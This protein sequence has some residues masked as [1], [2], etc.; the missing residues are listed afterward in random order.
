MHGRL[1]EAGYVAWTG[2]QV[3]E[4]LKAGGLQTQVA[5]PQGCS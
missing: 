1:H 5:A 2:L 3:Q 4:G